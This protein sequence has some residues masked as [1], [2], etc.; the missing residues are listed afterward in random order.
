[1]FVKFISLT[2]CYDMLYA[3][4]ISTECMKK[5]ELKLIK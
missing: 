4:S 1:M 5:S 2:A 3:G